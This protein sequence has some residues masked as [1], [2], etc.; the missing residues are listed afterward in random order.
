MRRSEIYKQAM[1]LW[2]CAVQIDIALE[3]M[4]ELSIAILKF[5]RNPEQ[6]A[7]KKEAIEQEIA[8]VEIMME[9]LRMI[10]DT[11]TISKIKTRKLRRLQ[12][13]IEMES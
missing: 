8:D 4:N 12:K 6:L 11:K 5:R 7:I 13:R 9:Q 2:G 10:F 1:D 3:E